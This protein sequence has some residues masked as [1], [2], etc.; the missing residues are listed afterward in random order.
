[1]GE[2]G[3]GGSG[4]GVGGDGGPGPTKARVL[5][6]PRIGVHAG[7]S[8]GTKVPHSPGRVTQRVVDCDAGRIGGELKK[9]ARGLL[10]QAPDWTASGIDGGVRETVKVVFVGLVEGGFA[11]EEVVRVVLGH[12]VEGGGGGGGW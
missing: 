9:H 3:E 5:L 12:V 4:D 2:S 10:L 11:V 6:V 1:M 8:T 7:D